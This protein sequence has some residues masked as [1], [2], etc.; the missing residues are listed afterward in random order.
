MSNL[1]FDYSRALPFV[2]QEEID[3]MADYVK[4]AQVRRCAS[5]LIILMCGASA[6]PLREP[7][8]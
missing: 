4:V 6:R 3:A 7:G 1:T 8:M 5:F 2:S